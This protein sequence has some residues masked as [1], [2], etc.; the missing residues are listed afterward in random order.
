MKTVR[1]LAVAAAIALFILSCARKQP[2]MGFGAYTVPEYEGLETSC[3][4]ARNGNEWDVTVSVINNSSSDRSFKLALA[5]EPGFKA[6][7]WLVPGVN[8]D[9]NPYGENMP[10]GWEKDDEPWVFS[11]DRTS[12]PSCT[13][14][15]NR[16]QVFALFA[17]DADTASYVSSC[18]MEKL[19]D[20]SFRHIIY[21]PDSEGPVCYSGKQSF[22]EGYDNYITLGPGESFEVKAFACTGRPQWKNYGFAEV[23]PSA[24]KHLR[25]DTPAKRSMEEVIRLDKAFQDWSR[26]RDEHGYWYGGIVDDQVF[27]AGYYE[28]GKSSDGY[29]VADYDA[30]PSL[31]RWATDEIEQSKHLA[32]GEY[33]RGAGRSIGFGAQSF[34]MARL[35]I[36]NGLR[37]GIRE[38]V[39]FGLAVFRSWNRERRFPSG[40]Y[41]SYKPRTDYVIN[42]SNVGWAISELSRTAALLK[43][44]GMEE[45]STELRE[46]ASATVS[47]IL[48]GVRK[49]GNVG[50]LWKAETGEVVS[51]G[52]DSAGYVLMGLVR[53]WQLTRDDSLLPLFK[54]AFAYYYAKDID[55]FRCSGGAMD[56]VSVDR[57]GIHP[58]LAAAMALFRETGDRKYLEY[59]RKAAWYFLSWLYIHNPVYG[60]DTDFSKYDWKPAG[61]T[62]VGA[63]H[64]A[65]DEY[66]CVLIPEFMELARIDCNPM[67]R[68][69]A[70]LVWRYSTQGFA[71]GQHRIWHGLERPAGSKNEAVFPTR[72]SKYHLADKARGSINDHL[73]AWGGTYRL[74]SLLELSE[75]DLRWLDEQSR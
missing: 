49:D 20:G 47:T 48:K 73:T 19:S 8:Y 39:D 14:S 60:P 31:N 24:W 66:A 27:C 71:D 55:F 70:A 25:H 28:S 52:G 68:D 45:A 42:A 26:R 61:A 38:D 32:P 3:N 58:F 51:R 18:S 36:E 63:E 44:Y 35:S 17:S 33:V 5:A 6:E 37:K 57:E 15:E 9:G 12:I 62:I 1:L 50:S 4:A 46:A 10:Q 40:L 2:S 23:F 72:W 74:A 54:K 53:W 21:W 64:P 56:C 34:Q 13:L 69:V 75:E 7:S 29:T 16:R 22:T 59:A 30:D 65:L 11:Y 43:E 41:N 67:W